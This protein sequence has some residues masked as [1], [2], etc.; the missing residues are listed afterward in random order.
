[1]S[2][3]LT[4]LLGRIFDKQGGHRLTVVIY[5]VMPLAIG[6]LLI[7]QCVLYIAP[8]SW[9]NAVT[10]FYPGLRVIFLLAFLATATKSINDVLWR[11]LINTYIQ[12]SLPR[13]DL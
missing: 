1:M 7:A 10:T 5:S 2:V 12:K 3:P 13:Q 9:R 4:L 11:S 6:L 8:V